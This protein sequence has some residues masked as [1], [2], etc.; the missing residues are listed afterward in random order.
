MDP[1]P[2]PGEQAERDRKTRALAKRLLPRA[3]VVAVA[4]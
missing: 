3:Q 4:P 2:H 1:P